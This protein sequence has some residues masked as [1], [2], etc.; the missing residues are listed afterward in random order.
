MKQAAERANA[1]LGDMQP[2]LAPLCNSGLLRITEEGNFEVSDDYN[3]SRGNIATKN[4]SG[5]VNRTQRTPSCRAAFVKRSELIDA[6]A[7]RTLQKNKRMTAP[8]LAQ[9]ISKMNI[10]LRP[11]VTEE[12]IAN[13]TVGLIEQELLGR[14]D[15]VFVYRV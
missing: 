6:A 13:R 9:E 8:E 10:T 1:D 5:L 7:V 4:H 12:E 14:D 2:H 11:D 15:D 3:G